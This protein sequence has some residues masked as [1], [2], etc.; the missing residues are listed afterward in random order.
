MTVYN[1]IMS[2]LRVSHKWALGK[3]VS[4]AKFVDYRQHLQESPVVKQYY[5]AAFLANYHTCMY[6][7][8]HT[9]AFGLMPPTL[10]DYLSQ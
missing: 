9:S 10:A 3:I 5:M 2:P 6:G 7:A 4:R 8:Q 1:R